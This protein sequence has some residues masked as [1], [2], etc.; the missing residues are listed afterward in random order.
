MREAVL[1]ASRKLCS[2]PLASI[3]PTPVGNEGAVAHRVQRALFLPVRVLVGSHGFE[4]HDVVL[5]DNLDD[6]AFDIRDTLADQRHLDLPSRNGR[7]PE[8]AE[9]VGIGA[10]TC[11]DTD[12]RVQHVHRGNGNHTFPGFLERLERVIPRP[13]SNGESRRE[14]QHHGPGQGGDV[15]LLAVA[16][17][18]Q[19]DRPRFQ[20]GKSLVQSHWAHGMDG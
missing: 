20:Q 3:Q 4:H 12:H 2:H 5:A 14:V 9:L 10:G 7:Q 8:F 16:G 17:H 1:H 6:P 19:H 18:Q 11:A 13:G 15:V